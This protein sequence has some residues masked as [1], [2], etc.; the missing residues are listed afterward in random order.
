MQI[1]TSLSIDNLVFDGSN[2]I[3]EEVD[4]LE[5]PLTRLPRYNWP[6]Q[7]GAFI[8]NTLYGERAIKIKGT[9]NAPDGTVN[10]YLT[11][12]ITLINALNYKRDI[13]NDIIPQTL[14]V[15]LA[16]GQILTCDVY[17]DT[18]LTMAFSPDVTD[19]A[20]FLIT[21]IA[22]DPNLYSITPIITSVNFPING[23]TAIPTAIPI[24]LAPSSGG[25]ATINNI[26]STTAYPVI[27]INAPVVDPYIINT[28][29]NLYM[30][31]IY[32]LNIGDDPLIVD[33]NAQTIT[34]GVNDVTGIQ[35]QGSTFF[36]LISG[37]NQIKYSGSSGSGIATISFSPTFIG[38]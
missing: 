24:S 4:G 25:S 15:G 2:Y 37:D 31:I 20:E 6:G 10:T 27:T 9:L 19:Y 23:G 21:L 18:P 28:T 36:G 32:T 7:N 1:I 34:Q 14:T 35:L 16:N 38:V 26:G 8:S 12:R 11:N 29:T 13:N 3:L 30:Q 33:C 22:P 17:V 5:L